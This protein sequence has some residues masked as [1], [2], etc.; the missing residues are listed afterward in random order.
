MNEETRINDLFWTFQGEGFNTGRRALFVRLPFCNLKCLFC[1]TEFN[2]FKK[3]TK[4]EFQEFAKGEPNRFAVITGGE[5]TVNKDLEK[6]ISWLKELDFEIAIESNGT[7]PIPLEIDFVT[8]SPKKEADYF[9]H[10]SNCQRIDDLKIVV[11]ENFDW[12]IP[13]RLAAMVNYSTK[14]WLSPEFGQ[15][16][17]KV[18]EIS[19]YISEDPRWRLNLQTHKF[20]GLK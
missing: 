7:F 19:K 15:L 2:T 20:V 3:M 17:E 5:P 11:D 16:N 4:E 12:M 13:G 8:V 1:D 14:L 10:P 18:A 6:V 9:I